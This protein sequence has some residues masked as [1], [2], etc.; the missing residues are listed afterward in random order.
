MHL[1]KEKSSISSRNYRKKKSETG[2]KRE[3]IYH[4]ATKKE[5]E[6]AVYQSLSWGIEFH[7]RT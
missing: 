5:E 3:V 2:D 1:Q 7:G 6:E 4:L